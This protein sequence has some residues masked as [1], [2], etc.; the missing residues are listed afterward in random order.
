[1]S[2]LKHAMRFICLLFIVIS[3]ISCDDGISISLN[4]TYGRYMVSSATVNDRLF[5]TDSTFS[6][7]DNNVSFLSGSYIYDGSI[8]TLTVNGTKY[9]KYANYSNNVLTISGSGAYSDYFND[10]WTLR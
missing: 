3:F 4:G 10:T 6:S 1:M 5:F 9:Q 2:L 8:L 7:I